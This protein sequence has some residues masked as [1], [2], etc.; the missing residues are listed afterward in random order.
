MRRPTLGT[1]V[2]HQRIRLLHLD[3]LQLVHTCELQKCQEGTDRPRH[4][5]LQRE[6]LLKEEPCRA[7][8]RA[9]DLAH[10]LLDRHL[11]PLNHGEGGTLA[12]LV[13]NPL[14]CGGE[15]QRGGLRKIEGSRRRR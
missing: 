15:I 14:K 7:G 10:R 6:Q 4:S 12:E 11:F 13:E 3:H 9:E 1:Q 5:T 2:N 8:L